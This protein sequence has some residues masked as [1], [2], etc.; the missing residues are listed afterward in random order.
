MDA[1]RWLTLI[2]YITLS[3][4]I[5]ALAW[6][7]PH[8]RPILFAFLLV[9]F[10]GVLFQVA[11]IVR[12]SGGFAFPTGVYN[13]WSIVLRIHTIGTGIGSGWLYL[14]RYSP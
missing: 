1:L 13:M 14:N 12:A 8:Y 7:V 3:V 11:T 6:R 10:D 4:I 2:A 5:V 9:T